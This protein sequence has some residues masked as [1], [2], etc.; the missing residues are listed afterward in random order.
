MSSIAGTYKLT[1]GSGTCTNC[2]LKS[3]TSSTGSISVDACVCNVGYTGPDGTN[4]AECPI[5]KYKSNLGS[6]ACSSCPSS[7]TPPGADVTTVSTARAAV[8]DC[9]CQAGFSG[10]DGG[11]CSSCPSGTYKSFTGTSLCVSCPANTIAPAGSLTADDCVCTGSALQTNVFTA[12]TSITVYWD[13]YVYKVVLSTSS[14]TRTYGGTGG[15]PVVYDINPGEYI[16]ETIYRKFINTFGPYLGCG[17]TFRTSRGRTIEVLGTY[18]NIATDCGGDQIFSTSSWQPATGFT[19][20]SAVST[21]DLTGFLT[22]VRRECVICELTD[23]VDDC[24]CAVGKTKVNNACVIC[25]DNTYKDTT[26]MWGLILLIGLY[27]FEFHD[28]S[29]NLV[30]LVAISCRNWRMHCLSVRLHIKCRI[31][32]GFCNRLHM[33]CRTYDYRMYSV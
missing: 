6:F 3:T 31:S 22:E 5:G 8:S 25:P 30:S 32:P 10:P 11:A 2:P 23:F 20:A 26:G 28:R 13:K 29:T 14:G 9:K 21:S 16:V 27:S 17:I 4:C 18:Y 1:Q 12:I 7:S 33:C 15:T 24:T 19:Q